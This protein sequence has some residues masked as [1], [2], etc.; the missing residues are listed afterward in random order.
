MVPRCLRAATLLAATA[1]FPCPTVLAQDHREGNVPVPGD[2]VD[3]TL[4]GL[5]NRRPAA[6]MDD[7]EL[8]GFAKGRRIE[9]LTWERAYSLA[10]V[11]HRATRQSREMSLVDA[12]DPEDLTVH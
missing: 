11:G 7:A 10:L 1:L 2:R 12:L 8:S 5:L 3:H 6:G 9:I 4:T